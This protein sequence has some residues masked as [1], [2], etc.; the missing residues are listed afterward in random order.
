MQ[1]AGPV[2]LSDVGDNVCMKNIFFCQ[3]HLATRQLVH[4]SCHYTDG[5][6]GCYGMNKLVSLPSVVKLLHQPNN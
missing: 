3:G 4:Q 1:L 5:R 2:Q 6:P